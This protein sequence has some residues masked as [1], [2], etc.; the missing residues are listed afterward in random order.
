MA[1]RKETKKVT[2]PINYFLNE[3][4]GIIIVAL[5]LLVGFSIIKEPMGEFGIVFKNMFT[6]LLGLGS[7]VFP[8]LTLFIG[9]ALILIKE[10][11]KYEKDL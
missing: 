8:I 9:I 5:S 7:Y 10:D 3:I 4:Y 1:V 2:K 6:G 11:L